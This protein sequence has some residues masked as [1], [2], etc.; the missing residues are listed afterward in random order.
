MTSNK[1]D[2]LK[3]LYDADGY[4][5]YIPNKI[6]VQKLGVSP[7]S[8]SEMLLKLQNDGLIEY[9]A[10]HGSKLTEKG[11]AS[12]MDVVRCHELWEVFL[13]KH[14]GYTWWEAHEEAHLLEHVA[15][16]RMIDR[17]DEF[18]GHPKTCPHGSPI[19]QKEQPVLRWEVPLKS[20]SDLKLDECAEIARI[21]EDRH[22]LD[23]LEP[24]GIQPGKA[25]R[26]ISK[27]EYE[28]PIAFEQEGRI[29]HISYK[30]A[31]LIYVKPVEVK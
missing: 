9:R 18:L 28:G 27:D 1:E 17:L 16:T 25:I 22:L 12:C 20:V 29:I 31:T 6:L 5:H 24:L 4:D 2:Y 13:I 30:A 23:Y 14:L 19:P 15:S 3:A 8:V 26:I 10:Y 21:T 7:A 11:L